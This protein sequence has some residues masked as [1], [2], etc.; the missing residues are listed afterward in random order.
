MSETKTWA[1]REVDLAF[2]KSEKK[3]DTYYNRMCAESALK[4][5]RSL[6]EDNHSGLSISVT[7]DILKRLVDHKPLT[8]LTGCEEEWGESEHRKNSICYQNKRYSALFKDVYDDGAM[9]YHDV[10]R[11]VIYDI[12]N[13]EVPWSNG[14][15]ARIIDEMFPIS[16]PYYPPETPYRVYRED[17]LFDP[18]NGDYDTI[19][20][21]YVIT[22][23]G[24]NI[25]IQRYFKEDENTFVEIT[26]EEYIER[27][28]NRYVP[29]V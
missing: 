21:L 28:E 15:V 23:E 22:P 10:N 16:M 12:H 18:K 6:L 1:E 24:E 9:V 20:L 2:P 11:V 13:P 27:K 25:P 4:A 3:D 5:L 19:A 17:I 7:M 8:E 14:F 29:S 26:Q